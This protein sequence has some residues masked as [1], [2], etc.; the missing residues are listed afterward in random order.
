[1]GLEGVVAAETALSDVDGERGILLY[2]GKRADRLAAHCDFEAVAGLLISGELSAATTAKARAAR[3]AAR[4]I[5]AQALPVLAAAP[6]LTPLDLMRTGLSAVAWRTDHLP[7]PDEAYALL[8]AMPYLAAAAAR[9]AAGLAAVGQPQAEDDLRSTASL[10]LSLLTGAEPEPAEVRALD[11]Y[12]VLT[13]EHSLNA[14]TFAVRVAASTHTD[15]ASALV[16]G[17]ATLKGPLHGGAPTGV[18]D[19]LDR[20]GSAG[21]AEAWIEGELAAGRRLMGFGHRVYRTTDPRAAAL[22]EIATELSGQSA[23]LDLYV[24]VEEVALAALARRHPERPLCTNCEFYTAAVHR[25]VGIPPEASPAVFA[26]ARTAGWTAH[27]LEQVATGRL[28][29]PLAR[30]TGPPAVD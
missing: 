27:A 25:M 5:A 14:S 6:S 4:A 19:M 16:A 24:A 15:L 28:I 3:P 17:M 13:A 12:L 29:R 23:L 11:A 30:Y 21:E 2:R 10:F 1:M 9:R 8:G 7:T 20:I 22:R 18:A 26:L